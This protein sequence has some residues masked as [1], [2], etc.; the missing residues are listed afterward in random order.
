[1]KILQVR[2]ALPEMSW[3]KSFLKALLSNELLGVW[4]GPS[5][6]IAWSKKDSLQL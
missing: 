1:M 4:R 5:F 3:E 6:I 2:E